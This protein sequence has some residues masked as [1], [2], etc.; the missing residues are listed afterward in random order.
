[1]TYIYLDRWPLTA[2]VLPLVRSLK[3][4][5]ADDILYVNVSALFP[6][7][8]QPIDFRIVNYQE[9]ASHE[10]PYLLIKSHS[11]L[12]SLA[13]R[14]FLRRDSLVIGF[15]DQLLDLYLA[16]LFAFIPVYRLTTSP[17]HSVPYKSVNVYRNKLS[18]FLHL[19]LKPCNILS[20]FSFYAHRIY[21]YLKGCN[22]IEVKICAVSTLPVLLKSPSSTDSLHNKTIFFLLSRFP[23]V[24]SEWFKLS[25]LP[26]SPNSYL[27]EL[28]AVIRDLESSRNIVLIFHPK[29][30]LNS[31]FFSELSPLVSSSYLGFDPIFLNDYPKPICITHISSAIHLATSITSCYQWVPSCYRNNPHV[32]LTFSDFAATTHL[33]AITT[34]E[35]F[36]V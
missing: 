18:K 8:L 6:F 14:S 4:Q 5:L 20:I 17:N 21:R 11:S 28:K 30:M 34:D 13:F 35:L 36:Y 32:M 1:M 26:F 9:L 19:W 23:S 10:I 29:T 33:K 27:S 16:F 2:Q 3:D 25:S 24:E 12:L 15:A 31:Q 7:N 22:T